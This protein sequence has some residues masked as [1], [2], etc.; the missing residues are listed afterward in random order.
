MKI[1]YIKVEYADISLEALAD[2]I[3]SDYTKKELEEI[4][5]PESLINTFECN[6]EHFLYKVGIPEDAE[7][8]LDSID[9][10]INTASKPL[11]D[12]LAKRYEDEF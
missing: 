7:V 10:L 6:T 5:S 3:W 1:P 11:L 9:A 12:I 8:D 4:K 2:A